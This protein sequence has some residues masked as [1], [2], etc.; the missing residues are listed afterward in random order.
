MAA[1]G[2]PVLRPLSMGQILDQAIRI[3]RRNFV[4]FV[5]IVAAVQVPLMVIQ[6]LISMATVRGLFHRL[7]TPADSLGGLFGPDYFLGLLGNVVISV[8]TLVLLW[9]G[10]AAALARVVAD[11][12][13]GE[14]ITL[15]EAYRRIVK[16]LPR[17]LGAILFVMVLC[18]GLIIWLIV[19]CVGWLTGPGI[20]FLLFAAI[21]PLVAPAIVIEGQPALRAIRRAWDLVRRRFWWVVGFVGILFLFNQLIVSGPGAL[22][23][24]V[25]QLGAGRL[26][27]SGDY[28]TTLIAQTVLQYVV[29]LVLS[30]IYLPLQM[31]C[32][33]LMYLDLRVRTEG[34]DLDV[35]AA[36][37][38]PE[39]AR[40]A[41]IL[42]QAAPLPTSNLV[43]WQE[44]G[45]FALMSLGAIAAVGLLYAAL[46][47]VAML[48]V[49]LSS[50][51]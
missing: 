39:E 16:S 1:P 5:G 32:L 25:L 29:T 12:Y 35:S 47:A 48:I 49:G 31:T 37:S 20:L 9:G 13:A 41:D 26:L 30:L 17:L 19:P 24:V 51:F 28:A 14:T 44:M 42:A 34:F 45:Y 38:L 8:L 4:K 23:Q 7:E 27:L 46:F 18:I 15:V 11:Q 10:A 50:G 3:Y 33:T 2:I 22:L 36:R 6:A 21:V 40:P 43:T